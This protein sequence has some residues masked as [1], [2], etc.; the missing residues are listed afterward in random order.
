MPLPVAPGGGDWRPDGDAGA[1]VD[2]LRGHH[3]ALRFVIEG[4]GHAGFGNGAMTGSGVLESVSLGVGL[5]GAR[6][7]ELHGCAELARRI[8]ERLDGMLGAGHH[9]FDPYSAAAIDGEDFVPAVQGRLVLHVARVYGHKGRRLAHF[10]P[11]EGWMMVPLAYHPGIVMA[12]V[13]PVAGMA[14]SPLVGER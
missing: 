12:A 7:R 1:A 11:A 10:D 8:L 13:N 2:L 3:K 6:K 4:D 14:H 9:A 5:G